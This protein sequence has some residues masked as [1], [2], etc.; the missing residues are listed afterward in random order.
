MNFFHF[1]FVISIGFL[2]VVFP[3]N[4]R[5]SIF[6]LPGDSSLQNKSSAVPLEEITSEEIQGII[7]EM[8]KIAKGERQDMEKQV[9]VGLA[10]PQIG[11]KKRIILVDMGVDATRK[12]LGD[13][14]AFINPEIISY[15]SEIVEGR[16]GCYSV[17]SKLVG[18]VPRSE[19]IQARAYDRFG[20]LKEF[21]LKGFTAR[22]FQHEVDHLEGIRFP[23][24]VGPNGILHWVQEEEITDYRNSWKTWPHICSWKEWEDM[25]TGH[26]SECAPY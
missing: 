14:Q 9:L 16:E 12:E 10:A 26:S 23:D 7:D 1:I 24:R 20:K 8:Y 5:S 4:K 21:E 25:K 17:D 11:I 19:C 22:I 15:S 18:I 3:E 2:S 13:L 6:V